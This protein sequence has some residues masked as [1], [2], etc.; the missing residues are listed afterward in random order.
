MKSAIRPGQIVVQ[1]DETNTPPLRAALRERGFFIPPSLCREADDGGLR[2]EAPAPPDPDAAPQARGF[3]FQGD[4]SAPPE[5]YDAPTNNFGNGGGADEVPTGAYGPVGGPQQP[6][7]PSN[8]GGPPPP[9]NAGGGDG[10]PL[11]PATMQIDYRQAASMADDLVNKKAQG[12]APPPPDPPQPD[13]SSAGMNAVGESTTQASHRVERLDLSDWGY[14]LRIVMIADENDPEPTNALNNLRPAIGQ[15]LKN[16]IGQPG[17][18]EYDRRFRRD[19]EKQLAKFLTQQVAR[20]P[21]I[22]ADIQYIE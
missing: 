8:T 3:S 21:V 17:R 18:L 16:E 13:V 11:E 4:F 20:F 7:P 22:K 10:K 12:G 9:Q 2:R 19:V 5:A 15:W 14:L 1:P 6:P